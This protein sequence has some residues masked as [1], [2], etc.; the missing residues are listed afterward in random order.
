[1]AGGIVF[2]HADFCE[3]RDKRGIWKQGIFKNRVA[4][5]VIG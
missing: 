2:K 1:M 4:G 3:L 5:D